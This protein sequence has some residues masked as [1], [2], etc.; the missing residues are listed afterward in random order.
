MYV[1]GKR[2]RTWRARGRV[3]AR[4]DLRGLPK[5]RFMARIV[6]RTTKGRILV[7]K[8]RY[9]TCVSGRGWRKRSRLA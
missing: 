9:R 1:R 4:V 7:R 3:R 5:G 6:V 8:R 2:V